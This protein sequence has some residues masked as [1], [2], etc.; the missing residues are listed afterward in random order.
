ME[1]KFEYH[2]HQSHSTS[3]IPPDLD[4]TQRSR[5]ELLSTY[6][7]GE[8]SPD[9]RKQVQHWL[10]TDPQT[11]QLYCRLL[12]LRQK[13]QAIPTPGTETNPELATE[14]FKRIDRQRIRKAALWGSGAIATLVVGALGL[15][16]PR[17]ALLSEMPQSPVAEETTEPLLIAVNQPAVEIPKT[18]IAPDEQYEMIPMLDSPKKNF[19]NDSR[20]D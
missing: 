18:A 9:E 4:V 7:D 2:L 6:L 11:K 20:L 12:A 1:S 17:P 10:D 8:V 13:I 19:E 14:V 5:F 15:F 16:S 3:E